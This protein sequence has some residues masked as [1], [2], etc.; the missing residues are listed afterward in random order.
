MGVSYYLT[1]EAIAG[2]LDRLARLL[3]PGSALAFDYVPPSVIDN[4]QYRKD[5]KTCT[6]RFTRSDSCT[7]ETQSAVGRLGDRQFRG[8]GCDGGIRRV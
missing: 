6:R 4:R 7:R 5:A 8:G 2:T 1:E 3:A